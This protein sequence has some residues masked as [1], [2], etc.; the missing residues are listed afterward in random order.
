MKCPTAKVWCPSDVVV[1]WTAPLE[2]A[3][4]GEV[5]E[6]RD[7]CVAIDLSM[8]ESNNLRELIVVWNIQYTIWLI[9]LCYCTIWFYTSQILTLT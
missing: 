2:V 6:A 4:H 7:H 3:G 1:R 5:P 9:D 8:W